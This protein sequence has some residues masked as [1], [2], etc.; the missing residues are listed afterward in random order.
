LW[1]F[2]HI[3]I[4]TLILIEIYNQT[5]FNTLFQAHIPMFINSDTQVPT[6]QYIFLDSSFMVCLFKYMFYVK[7]LNIIHKSSYM[8]IYVGGNSIVTSGWMYA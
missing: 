7:Y 3:Y 2:I 8:V 6:H 5:Y 4:Y 1:E